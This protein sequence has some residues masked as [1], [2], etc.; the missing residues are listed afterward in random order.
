[1][2]G[3]VR[4]IIEGYT[5][6][7]GVRSLS[8]CLAAI[9]RHVAVQ[10]VQQREEEGSSAP[11]LGGLL[12]ANSGGGSSEQPDLP[13]GLEEAAARAA[14]AQGVAAN[15]GAA[16]SLA[17]LHSMQAMHSR[18]G[19][20][21]VQPP[22]AGRD[23]S[24]MQLWAQLLP[25]AGSPAAVAA[26]A[27]ATGGYPWRQLQPP[28]R[29]NTAAA[30]AA[31]AATQCT[32]PSRKQPR[33]FSWLRWARH[34]GTAEQAQQEASCGGSGEAAHPCSCA[35]RC[36]EPDCCC[37]SHASREQPVDGAAGHEIW[38]PPGE[39]GMAAD[40]SSWEASWRQSA[41]AREPPLLCG[42]GSMQVLRPPLAEALVAAGGGSLN[43]APRLAVGVAAAAAAA[44]A[45]AGRQH[46]AGLALL[47]D[48]LPEASGAGEQGWPSVSRQ[49]QEQQQA[50]VVNDALIEVVLGPR[51]FEGHNNA[52]GQLETRE[53]GGRA[54]GF[55]CS[56]AAPSQVCLP[57]FAVCWQ[58]NVSQSQHSM[59]FTWCST[60]PPNACRACGLPRHC[61]RPG[62][63]VC[64]R[65]SAVH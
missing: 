30:E 48:G 25:L 9:C 12:G 42:P 13:P 38:G 55:T 36:G 53:T 52:G 22:S 64:G 16:M 6:E 4:S 60:C 45:A 41:L 2:A 11:L 8:R 57:L 24:A 31:A 49:Q 39:A 47:L 43:A 63:D 7:A 35:G 54:G 50:I 33:W 61:R 27:T 15:S 10:V 19:G 26:T 1:M 3:G 14:A 20:M 40:S 44:R 58:R 59:A 21:L 65:Q 28:M 29:S 32:C 34:D 56:A 23:N 5:S 46:G 51:R 62:V 37:H 17:A 18:G